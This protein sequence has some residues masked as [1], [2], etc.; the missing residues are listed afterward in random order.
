MRL[1]PIFAAWLLSACTVNQGDVN[2]YRLSDRFG[3]CIR[4]PNSA[5]YQWQESRIDF[6]LGELKAGSKKVHVYIGQQ[7][8]F[9]SRSFGEKLSGESGFRYVGKE[10]SG[11]GQK[12]LWS[13]KRYAQRG[14]LFV[15]FEGSDLSSIEDALIQ[16]HL[17]VDCLPS[18]W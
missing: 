9:D 2:L 16:K 1:I 5:T 4:L 3:V 15:M 12:I 17:L 11:L 18:K 6:D 14:P 13:N 7:P 8:A 10:S